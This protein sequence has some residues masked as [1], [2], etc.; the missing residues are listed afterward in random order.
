MAYA[1]VD[2][3]MPV[4]L[5]RALCRTVAWRPLRNPRP[6]YT[7]IVACPVELSAMLGMVFEV[8]SR[9][10]RAGLSE[11]LV[12]YDRPR[13][14]LRGIG[15][16]ALRRRYP[17]V[18]TRF[19]YPGRAAALLLHGLHW[20]TLTNWYSWCRGIKAVTT[21]HAVLHD[22]DAVLL[23][24]DFLR[25]RF[26]AVS[27]P[28]VHYCGL[29]YVDTLGVHG[30]DR[31]L[32]TQELFFD[33]AFLRKALRP[34]DCLPRYAQGHRVFYDIL[35]HAQRIAGRGICMPAQECVDWVHPYWMICF[36]KRLRYRPGE[37]AREP[38]NALLIPY[39]CYAAGDQHALAR[40][41]EAFARSNGRSVRCHEVDIPLTRRGLAHVALMV[42]QMEAAE[43]M[44][45]GGMRDEVRRYADALIRFTQDI[46]ED[47]HGSTL[48]TVSRQD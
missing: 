25:T 33:A 17:Y 5:L 39:Y 10:D 4:A 41:C 20:E 47:T 31:L 32:A 44:L 24:P 36:Y 45:C 19:L 21:R 29:R 6:G 27:A 48:T 22:V 46:P 11:V 8:L 28:D 37:I 15:E 16:A 43:R 30:D 40:Q 34:F 26:C 12:V 18:R 13:P 2:Y 14:W 35:L 23:K 7:L 38:N 42:R 1:K 3:V 9:Q